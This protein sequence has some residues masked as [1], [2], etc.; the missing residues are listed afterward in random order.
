MCVASMRWRLGG[1]SSVT[2]FIDEH[3]SPDCKPTTHPLTHEVE[4][5]K[6]NNIVLVNDDKNK[7]MHYNEAR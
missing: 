7:S 6:I 3:I 2:L 5:T 1:G 4:L